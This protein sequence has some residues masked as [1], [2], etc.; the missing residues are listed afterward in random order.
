MKKLILI[1]FLF[2]LLYGGEH[3]RYF[4][5]GLN[6][7]SWGT[8]ILVHGAW[9]IYPNLN[10]GG[11]FRFYDIKA[12]DEFVMYDYYYDYTYTVNE[13]SL[14]VLP[15]F[16]TLYYYPFEGKIENNFSPFISVK[17][18]PLLTLDG[19]E[20]IESFLER[21]QKAKTHLTFGGFF[22]IGIDI[23]RASGSIISVGVGGDFLPMNGK[24]DTNRYY[25]GMLLNF[26]FSRIR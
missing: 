7:G 8:G 17:A 23:R 12:K 22:G 1:I 15:L 5:F 11:E 10:I 26:T 19:D 9:E 2:T 6:L 18:G 13:Q 20:R 4:G 21:W 16:A 24:V 14:V 3:E 25:N